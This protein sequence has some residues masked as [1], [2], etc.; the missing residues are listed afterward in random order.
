MLIHKEITNEYKEKFLEQVC[1]AVAAHR[2][3]PDTQNINYFLKRLDTLKEKA[4]TE[5]LKE[6]NLFEILS[7]SPDDELEEEL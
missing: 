1:G 6:E 2:T 3:E 7:Y 4:N 5:G